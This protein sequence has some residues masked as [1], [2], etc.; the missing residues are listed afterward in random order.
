MRDKEGGGQC[1]D[2]HEQDPRQQ[3]RLDEIR[4]G[5]QPHQDDGETQHP[6]SGVP[7]A[8]LVGITLAATVDLQPDPARHGRVEHQH[9]ETDGHDDGRHPR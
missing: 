9:A 2:Q 5:L 4:P 7:E 1:D 8:P 6:L 3:L